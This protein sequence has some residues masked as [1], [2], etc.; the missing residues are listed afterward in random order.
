[1]SWGSVS[2]HSAD[3]ALWCFDM[4]LEEFI[5]FYF[6]MECSMYRYLVGL[7]GV[8]AVLVLGTGRCALLAVKGRSNVLNICLVGVL[9]S[10]VCV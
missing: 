7:S 6:A 8:L 3:G 9:L 2:S 1:M 5:M 4:H 10:L